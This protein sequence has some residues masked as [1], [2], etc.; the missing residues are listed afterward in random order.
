MQNIDFNNF[1]LTD[2]EKAAFDLFKDTDEAILTFRQ[3]DILSDLKLIDLTIGNI[4]FYCLNL[5]DPIPHIDKGVCRLTD[6]GIRYREFLKE[7][8]RQS[9]QQIKAAK[10]NNRKNMFFHISGAVIMYLLGLFTE[11]IKAINV[12]I[13][14]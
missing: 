8:A 11:E 14:R 10:Q 1:H 9:A 7:Q 12:S 5:S 3:F 4:S 6:L 13:F 2:E